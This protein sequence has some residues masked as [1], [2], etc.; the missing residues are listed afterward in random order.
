MALYPSLKEPSKLHSPSGGSDSQVTSIVEE[1]PIKTLTVHEK[2]RA[3]QHD[4]F[5]V[6]PRHDT[7]D[8]GPKPVEDLIKLL[9]GPK[10]EQCTQ[11]S[12]DLPNHEYE[13]IA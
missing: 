7:I 10:L 2:T 5:D 13:H 3:N 9:L 4:T 11:L 12:K 6:D 1:F 8:K